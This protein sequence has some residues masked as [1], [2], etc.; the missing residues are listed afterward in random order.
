MRGARLKGGMI[1]RIKAERGFT[2]VELLVVMLILGILAAVA[3]PAFFSQRDK[4]RDAEAKAQVSTAQLAAETYATDNDGAYSGATAAAL[5]QIEE[6]LNNGALT[7]LAAGART[8]RLR[9]VSRSGSVFE[10]DRG[11]GG[12]AYSCNPAGTGGCKPDGT[13]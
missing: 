11:A 2:L 3:V 13:W 5:A 1:S 9:S 7:V 12:T 4:A 10:V 8:Y 6:T